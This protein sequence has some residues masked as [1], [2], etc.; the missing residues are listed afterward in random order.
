MSNKKSTAEA[1]EI[2]DSGRNLNQLTE[3]VIAAAIDVPRAL[4]PGRNRVNRFAV[5]DMRCAITHVFKVR[6]MESWIND[7]LQCRT[8]EAWHPSKSTRLFRGRFVMTSVSSAISA[9]NLY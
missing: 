8:F 4:G 7:Q 1:A 2:A 6:R 9:V 3:S 5:A